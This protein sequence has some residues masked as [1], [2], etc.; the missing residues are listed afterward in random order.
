MI[1]SKKRSLWRIED[2]RETY[3]DFISKISHS[4]ICWEQ[5]GGRGKCRYRNISWEDIAII[6]VKYGGSLDQDTDSRGIRG[7]QI[8][9]LFLR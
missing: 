1:L 9:D 6:Q 7:G 2:R 5:T 3:S 4:P 8:L